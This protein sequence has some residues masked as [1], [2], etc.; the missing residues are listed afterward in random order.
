[1][2]LL[3]FHF[4][5][6][7]SYL[8]MG[9]VR[10]LDLLNPGGVFSSVHMVNLD[11][12]SS[13]DVRHKEGKFRFTALGLRRPG[14]GRIGKLLA[15]RE[16]LTRL[17][18]E[19]RPALVMAEDPNL[20]GLA[21]RYVSRM[22]GAPYAVNIMYDSDL[23]H[24]LAGQPAL[25]FLR[26]RR[27]ESLLERLVLKG[28]NGVYGGS[29]GYFDFGLRHGAR[30][31]R[32]YLGSWSVDDVFYQDAP[33]RHPDSREMFFVGRLHPLKFI[34]DLLVALAQMPLE[35]RL[36]VAGEGADRNR[37]EALCQRL[38]LG[39][40]VRLLGIVPREELRARMAG[41][42]LLVAT[43]GVN[44][45]VECLLSGR[46]VVAYDNECNGEFV[47]HGDTGWL[48]PF[49]DISRLVAAMSEIVRDP[50]SAEKRGRRARMKMREEC[51]I[52]AC[53]NHRRDFI[54]NCIK[55]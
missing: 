34:D 8:K 38:G 33:A 15:Y 46:P 24:K 6:L 1:M 25:G 22:V 19:E 13:S 23:H 32:A 39:D 12:Q 16:A 17:G 5:T 47:R 10:Y 28:A 37:L 21:A 11:F 51:C 55:N 43:Q 2:H 36:D 9:K 26:S 45:V 18:R 35:I 52:S 3:Y 50:L 20:L 7:E 49:R 54:L 41:A 27:L 4:S 40:R 14:H 30:P 53:L 48:V 29:R 31:E 44:A 42:R